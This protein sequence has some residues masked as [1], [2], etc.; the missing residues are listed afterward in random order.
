TQRGTVQADLNPATITW[1]GPTGNALLITSGGVAYG[2]NLLT[3]TLTANITALPARM[4]AFLSDR[5]LALDD[6]TSTLQASNLLSTFFAPT[7]IAVRSAEADPWIAMTVVHNEI[8]LFGSLTTEVWYDAGAFPFPFQ[9]VP[10]AL[11]EQGIA[12]PFSATRDGSPLQWV[13]QNTQGARVIWQA[14]GYQP[15]RVST[16][17]IEAQLSTMTTV[18]DALSFTY[19]D[20]GHLLWCPIFPTADQAF[21]FDIALGPAGWGERLF[22]NTALGT[23]NALRV[24]HHVYAFDQHL[25]GDRQTGTI[26]TM[27]PTVYT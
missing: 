26:Y 12:A 15:Q 8:W 5:F 16:H 9:P 14:N 27:A 23:W 24:G 22:W 20:R 21:H 7:M 10:G 25:V 2:Y 4:G 18:A 3:N 13:G 6:T 19:Q 17:G 11:L 1:N